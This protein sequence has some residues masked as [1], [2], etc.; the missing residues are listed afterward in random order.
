MLDADLCGALHSYLDGIKIDDDQL[1][2]DAFKQV[3]PGNHFF[4]LRPHDAAL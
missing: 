2:L 3:G 4:W 1:A